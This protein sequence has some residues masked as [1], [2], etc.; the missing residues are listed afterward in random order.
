MSTVQFLYLNHGVCWMS[1]DFS[2]ITIIMTSIGSPEPWGPPTPSSSCDSTWQEPTQVALAPPSS[3]PESEGNVEKSRY[4]ILLLCPPCHNSLE[5]SL[6][7]ILPSLWPTYHCLPFDAFPAKSQPDVWQFLK[8]WH[9]HISSRHLVIS[10]C[11]LKGFPSF[12]RSWHPLFHKG[13]SPE[14]LNI[15]ILND[16]M[17][18]WLVPV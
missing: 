5:R 14:I 10:N 8:P 12:I 4:S 7:C 15:H 16:V 17:N 13:Q 9:I 11:H 6:S 1:Y 2:H 3:P 18:W